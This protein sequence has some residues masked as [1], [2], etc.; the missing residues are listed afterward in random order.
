MSLSAVL[1]PILVLT[2]LLMAAT[3]ALLYF[4]FAAR[5]DSN[6]PLLYY[7]CAAAYLIRFEDVLHPSYFCIGLGI[8]LLLRF[9]F[10]GRIPFRL[11]QVAE[12]G[13]LLWVLWRCYGVVLWWW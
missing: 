11:L 1:S 4:R 13:F 9:E 10:L 5:P 2:L 6:W 3:V 8:A 12:S 7:A